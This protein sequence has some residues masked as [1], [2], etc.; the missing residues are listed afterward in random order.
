M[1]F[2][3][4]LRANHSK[5]FLVMCVFWS[6]K[7]AS[8]PLFAPPQRWEWDVDLPAFPGDWVIGCGMP[9]AHRNNFF[10][11]FCLQ[12]FKK[13][14]CFLRWI[15]SHFQT[16]KVFSISWKKP[17]SKEKNISQRPSATQR[18]VSPAFVKKTTVFFL[19]GSSSR[20]PSFQKG[21]K[22]SGS[23]GGTSEW[24]V[25]QGWQNQVISK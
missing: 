16:S 23:S 6:L 7:M 20:R 25:S 4:K 22:C 17:T 21:Q 13:S 24:T 18:S 3:N 11:F 5:H 14:E 1:F 12:V 19:C 9:T 10:N 8:P 15:I 2:F